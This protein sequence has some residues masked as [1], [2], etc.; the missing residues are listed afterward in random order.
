[1]PYCTTLEVNEYNGLV[2]RVP[3]PSSDS[4]ARLPEQIGTGDNSATVFFTEKVYLIANTLVLSYGLDTDN[5]TQ[6]TLTTDYTVTDLNLGKIELTP[7]GVTAVGT[8]NIYAEYL[9]N[10]L[11][12]PDAE[13]QNA[14][15][16]STTEIESRTFNRFVDGTL[17]TPD[18]LIV[19]DEKLTGQGTSQ[20]NYFLG[21]YPARDIKTQLT[22][23][24]ATSP[25]P[26]SADVSSTDG[27]PDSGVVSIDTE[28]LTYS[29][30][31][32]TTF[33]FDAVTENHA[34]GD[35]VN[36]YVI[37][38]STTHPG[39]EP[40]FRV[41]REDADFDLEFDAGR[42]HLF[43]PL[44]EGSNYNLDLPLYQVPNRVRASYLYGTDT[45]PEDIERLCLM[46]ASKDLQ[47]TI[48]RRSHLAGQNDFTPN[49]IDVDEAWINQT[50]EKYKSF[51]STN[52]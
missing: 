43:E 9:Y 10:I 40:I 41:L 26:I 21:N 22:S 6:L 29:S 5:L 42:L 27:F 11:A 15:D 14:V 45:I 48:V 33:V 17:A 37:E 19:T 24:L 1:M 32:P 30:K 35:K 47:H 20:L 4:N 51:R 49:V 8:D 31:T 13:I 23:D 52:I 25:T 2:G 38:S 46:I 12:I 36:S 39:S 34:T 18:W 3:D 28:K 50:I 16:R 7:A 44:I